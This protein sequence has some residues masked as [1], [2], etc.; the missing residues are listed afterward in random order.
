M[1]AYATYNWEHNKWAELKWGRKIDE[2][3]IKALV[4]ILFEEYQLRY[5]KTSTFSMYPPEIRFWNK[6]GGE[7]CP[8]FIKLSNPCRINL[9]IHELTHAIAGVETEAVKNRDPWF[10]SRYGETRNIRIWHGKRFKTTLAQV[11]EIASEL[12]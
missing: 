9:I 3:E 11:Y 5:G 6:K 1:P 8:D 2:D 10:I 4:S 12:I 7:G